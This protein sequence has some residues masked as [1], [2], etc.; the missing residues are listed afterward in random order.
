MV[1]ANPAAVTQGLLRVRK[2]L[3]TAG[4]GSDGFSFAR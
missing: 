1:T 2:L 4:L 3:A